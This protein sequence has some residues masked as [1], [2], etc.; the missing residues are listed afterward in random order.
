MRYNWLWIALF[1]ALLSA[2]NDLQIDVQGVESSDGVIQVA[3]YTHK[4]AFLRTEGV[5]RTDSIPAKKGTTR[6]MLRDLP[7]GEYALAIFHDRNAN[8]HLDT[9][10]MGIPKEPLGFS[11]SRM[12]T[13]GPPSF[14]E[15]RVQLSSDMALAITLE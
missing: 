9:N 12:K 1:P 3:V 10:W 14:E 15:C 5:Y 2:Q 8:R 6:I 4:A 13:F 11:K 7:A